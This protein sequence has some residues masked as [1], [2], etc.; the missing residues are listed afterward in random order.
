MLLSII[1]PVYNVEKYLSKCIES[2]IKNKENKIEIILVDDGSK[3]TSGKICDKYA[4]LDFRIKSFHKKNGGLSDA[5]NYGIKKAKGK[6]LMFI[7][8]DDFIDSLKLNE[9]LKILK[10]IEVDVILNSYFEY[11]NGE[12]KNNLGVNKLLAERRYEVNN[13]LRAEIFEFTDGL[14]TAWKYIVKKEFLEMNNI[15]FK[16]GYLHEDVDYTTKIL[17]KMKSFYYKKSDFY[18]YRIEREGSIMDKKDIKSLKDTLDIVIDLNKF[19]IKEDINVELKNIVLNKL[20]KTFYTVIRLFS[21]GSLEEKEEII[22]K[23]KDNRYV[24][25]SSRNIKHIIFNNISKIIGFDNACK[26]VFR[27][28]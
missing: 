4:E 14:W 24:L 10:E 11:F 13:K 20:S 25:S 5:R 23:L 15:E 3:D 6:Y 16:K 7:D 17:L 1:V 27:L 22:S 2:I 19:M 21:N 12:L 26:I 28:G 8:S 9:I 18:Y